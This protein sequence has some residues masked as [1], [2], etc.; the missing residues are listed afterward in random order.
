MTRRIVA[1]PLATW[2]AP[3]IPRPL[4]SIPLIVSVRALRGNIQTRLSTTLRLTLSSHPL[5]P[6]VISLSLSY[7]VCFPPMRIFLPTDRF[8]FSTLLSSVCISSS[9]A[10]F[11]PYV[12]LS[13]FPCSFFC[14]LYMTAF[15]YHI[16]PY[17]IIHINKHLTD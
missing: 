5:F 7:L 8:S 14:S 11:S 13:F 17:Q 3:R 6:F 9:L 12:I 2:K 10:F 4:L 15:F 16:I 1:T